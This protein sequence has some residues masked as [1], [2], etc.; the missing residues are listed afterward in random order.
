M[1]PTRLKLLIVAILLIVTALVYWRSLGGEFLTWD[2]NINV[3]KNPHIQGLDAERITWMFTDTQVALRYKPLSWLAWAIVF[4]F[5]GLNPF[6][7]H[8][9]NLVLHCLNTVLLFLA[10]MAL[11]TA[12]TGGGALKKPSVLFVAAWAALL[13]ALHPLRVEPVAWVTGLPYDLCLFFLLGSLLFY[14]SSNDPLLSLQKRL[15]CYWCSVV[16]F[17][18][19][20]LAYPIGLGFPAVLVT[21]DWFLFDRFKSA[22][23]LFNPGG[24]WKCLV[25]KAPYA[26]IALFLVALAVYGRIPPE[27][28]WSTAKPPSLDEFGLASRAMQAC[29]ICIYYVWKFWFPFDLSPIYT[30]LLVFKPLDLPFISS[31]LLLALLSVLLIVKRRKWPIALALWICHLALLVPVF[32]LTEHPH[33]P[34]DRYGF[35]VGIIWPVLLGYGLLRSLETRHRVAAVSVSFVLLV[36]AALVSSRQLVFWHDDV[37]FF[38]YTLGT[39]PED[40]SFGTMVQRRLAAAYKTRK[41][42]EQALLCF[43]NILRSKPEDVSAHENCADILFDLGRFAEAQRHYEQILQIEPGKALHHNVMGCILAARGDSTNAITEFKAALKLEPAL[44]S[45]NR[46]MAA[47]LARLGMTA[48]AEF[49]RTQATVTSSKASRP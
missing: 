26:L 28:T 21:L 23:G 29:Y 11:F 48:E 9:A 4:E 3:S 36:G 17:L 44:A 43:A 18:L 33:F 34:S 37:S 24:A 49:Y 40:S 2:D 35:V 32:G 45:A 19:A 22:T 14:L 25:G 42:P 30:T 8:L 15:G 13:W 7:F 12:R 31:A 20:S 1:S 16:G 47:I 46:N 27:G 6:G 38:Q 10:V 39:L 5:G 41:Y